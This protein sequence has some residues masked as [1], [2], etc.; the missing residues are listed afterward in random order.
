[1]AIK[2]W[3][4]KKK[5][6]SQKNFLIFGNFF[7]KI[8]IFQIF[9]ELCILRRWKRLKLVRIISSSDFILIG[10]LP[11]HKGLQNNVEIFLPIPFS[12]SVIC[13]K[14]LFDFTFLNIEKIFPKKNFVLNLAFLDRDSTVAYYKVFHGV[15]KITGPFI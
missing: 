4:Q 13:L 3:I 5:I 6:N 2:F 8:S 12:T 15:K 1:M 7:E 10:V 11:N 9:N 14:Y